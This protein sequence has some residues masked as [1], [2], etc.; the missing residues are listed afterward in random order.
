MVALLF[1]GFLI[2]YTLVFSITQPNLSCMCSS[3]NPSQVSWEVV[4]STIH[5]K[6]FSSEGQV[7]LN[8][9]FYHDFTP[10]NIK[11]L[12]NQAPDFLL[13]LKYHTSFN[14]LLGQY[15]SRSHDSNMNQ[16]WAWLLNRY[17]YQASVYT[18]QFYHPSQ[19]NGEHRTFLQP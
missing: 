7:K 15:G 11:L 8:L 4:L 9:T 10:I 17:H 12:H 3:D 6:V 14:K 5:S 19:H 18:T 16:T 1:A 2:V 13:R